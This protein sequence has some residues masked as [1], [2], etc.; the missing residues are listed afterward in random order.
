MIRDS[1]TLIRAVLLAVLVLL[2]TGAAR[3]RAQLQTEAEPPAAPA[4]AEREKHDVTSALRGPVDEAEYI[5]GPGDRFS[6]TLWGQTVIYLDETVTPEGDLVL[7]G[8]AVIPVA[9]E[10]LERVKKDI[11]ERLAGLY[12][13]VEVSVSLVELREFQVNVLGAVQEPGAYVGTALDPA[14]VMI[15]EAGGLV[16]GASER[17]ISITRRGGGRA[18]VDIARYRNAGDLSADPPI[19]DGDVIFVPYAKAFVH[20]GG[21]VALPG[22][23]EFVDGETIGSLIEL[24]GGVVGGAARDTVE[25]R[26][27]IDGQTTRSSEVDVS[28]PDGWAFRLQEGDQ[29]LV[30]VNPDWRVP[31][32]VFVEGEVLYPGIYGINEGADRLSEVLARAG[33]PTPEASIRDAKLYRL[34]VSE[35]TDP[36]LERLR[37]IPVRDMSDTEYAY[38]KTMSR[39]RGGSVVVDFAQVLAGEADVPV[40]GDDRIVVPKVKVTV[41]V[42]GQ[43]ITPG[44]VRHVPGERYGY[45][46]KQAGGYTSEA[47][48]GG[49]R[50]IKRSTGQQMSARRAGAPEPGDVVWVPEEP[51][52]DLWAVLRET[53]ALLASLA[54]VYLVIDQATG[55]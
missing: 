55:R 25:V 34:P 45:Y 3:A 35:E 16:E 36:E 42:T 11:R 10:K 43:V 40:R 52:G 15:E 50:V 31:R 51:E 26:T 9:G 22:T 44:K 8:V 30:R 38:L 7:P 29:V 4:N 54:T 18:R 17:N 5:V 53:V 2:S 41:E 1:R 48:R 32:Q 20:V 28:R 33:G 46:V 12:R 49:T 14:S 13:N 47:H 37:L 27:F 19:L 21:G 24:A 23:Y 39:E 6:V